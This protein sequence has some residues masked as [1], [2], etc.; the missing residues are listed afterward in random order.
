MIFITAKFQ[1]RP[2]DADR[3]PQIAAEFTAGHPE[4]AGLPVVRLVPQCR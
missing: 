3:W 1:I 4:R 2:E